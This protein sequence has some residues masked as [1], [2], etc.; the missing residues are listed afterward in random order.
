M[1]EL[2]F[3]AAQET[4]RST[5]AIFG[6]FLVIPGFIQCFFGYRVLKLF[7]AFMGFLVG[8]VSFG[9]IGV[10]T[11]E[12]V[13]PGLLMGLVGGLL[14]ALLAFKAY[15]IAV[16]LING[17][18]V[19]LTLVAFGFFQGLEQAVRYFNRDYLM[20]NLIA[21]G[22]AGVV[23]AVVAMV[24]TALLFRPLIIC[25]SA[26]EG[27]L[28]LGGGLCMM[29]YVMDMI[30]PISLLCV[31]VGA[32][33]QFRNTRAEALILKRAREEAAQQAQQVQG[34]PKQDKVIQVSKGF[35][36]GLIA[37]E[38]FVLYAWNKWDTAGMVLGFFVVTFSSRVYSYF[39]LKRNYPQQ[40]EG[41]S[42]LRFLFHPFRRYVIHPE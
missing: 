23:L 37:V 32:A 31:V 29:L 7:A 27:G 41:I 25:S 17:I 19:F 22:A 4:V 13:G 1:L 8:L 11:L 33:F 24:L 12:A 20:Q 42:R 40:M 21:A 26:L 38:L 15:K 35:Y 2:L 3:G 9:I 5:L 28:L 16:C 14:L 39:L 30:A 10:A 18:N 34:T 6:L 36:A